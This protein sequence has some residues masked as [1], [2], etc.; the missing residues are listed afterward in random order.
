L[1]NESGAQLNSSYA[2]STLFSDAS[3]L[4]NDP[5]FIDNA[6]RGI[7]FQPMQA[8]DDLVTGEMWNRLFR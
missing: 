1:F 4:V 2:L 6:L 8:V 3:P 5:A 7:L